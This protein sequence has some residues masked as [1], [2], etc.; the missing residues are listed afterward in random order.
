MT[1]KE[2]LKDPR[3]QKKRLEIMQRDGFQC[4]CCFDRES[5]LVVHHKKYITNKEPWD[6]DNEYLITICEDCHDSI[7]VYLEKN[8]FVKQS[9]QWFGITVTDWKILNMRIFQMIEEQ[10]DTWIKTTIQLMTANI[11]KKEDI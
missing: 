6:Y 1:Y 2:K 4:Q 8:S 11:I 10:E 7:H 5:T 9:C 3:W